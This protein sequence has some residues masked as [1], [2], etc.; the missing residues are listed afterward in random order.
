MVSSLSINI[1]IF[2][3]KK[4]RQETLSLWWPE[5]REFQSIKNKRYSLPAAHLPEAQRTN[6][7]LSMLF[8]CYSAHSGSTAYQLCVTKLLSSYSAP[9]GSNDYQL[10]ITMLLSSCSAP[11]GST[12]YQLR[13]VHRCTEVD[14]KESFSLSD[15]QPS[16][17]LDRNRQQVRPRAKTPRHISQIHRRRVKFS[18]YNNEYVSKPPLN[19]LSSCLISTETGPRFRVCPCGST[20]EETDNEEGM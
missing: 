15:D 19:E 4:E 17:R 16:L 20:G 3:Y 10:C 11:T 6:C 9:S 2:R 7:V 5:I 8:S 14:N 13:Q 18:T 12:E 1:E